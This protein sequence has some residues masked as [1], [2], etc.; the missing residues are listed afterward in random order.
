MTAGDSGCCCFIQILATAEKNAN[1]N[2]LTN[3]FGRLLTLPPI[4][5]KIEPVR[6][7]PGGRGTR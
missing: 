5:T 4:L 1:V 7:S 2:E 6:K 3:R